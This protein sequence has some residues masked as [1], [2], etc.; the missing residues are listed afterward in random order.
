MACKLVI[1]YTIES[2]LFVQ[3]ADWSHSHFS[4]VPCLGSN[5]G[6]FYIF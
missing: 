3:S 2:V 6:I 5:G 4:Y 1:R